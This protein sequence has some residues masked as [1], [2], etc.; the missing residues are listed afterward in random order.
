MV[1]NGLANLLGTPTADQRWTE[2]RRGF[3]QMTYAS[4]GEPEFSVFLVDGLVVD[5][6]L[7]HE[8]PAGLGS[9]VLPVASVCS[10]LAI[11]Q[12]PAQAAR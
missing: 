9:L 10:E 11:G 8:R 12:T 1:R 6:K 3:E 5:V 7:G 4:A 2:A